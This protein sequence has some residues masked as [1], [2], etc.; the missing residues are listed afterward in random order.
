[1]IEHQAFCSSAKAHAP[2][3][4]IDGTCRVLQFA[5]YTFDA[6]LVEILTT[7]MVGACICIPSE[8]ER[9]NDIAGVINRLGVNH[10]VLTPS[11]VGFLSPSSVPGLRTLVLAGEAMSSSH[12]ATWSHIELVNGYG[13]AESSVAAVVNSRVT[14]SSEAKDIG[15]PCGVRCWVVDPRNHNRL[16][17][18][19]CVGE[20]LLEG[21]S[22]ARGYL[23]DPSKTEESFIFNPAWV[24]RITPS[25]TGE[26]ESSRRRFY[27]TG[28]LVRWNPGSGSLSYI[29]RK[30]TQIKFHGQRI[31][32]G[33]IE[34][35]LAIDDSVQHAMVLLPKLGHLAQHLV[36]VIS[37]S[38]LT[39]VSHATNDKMSG[40]AALK[41]IDDASATEPILDQV[42]A[43]LRMRLPAHMVPSTWVCVEAIPMLASRKMDRAAVTKWIENIITAEQCQQII[44]GLHAANAKPSLDGMAEH[45]TE[46]EAKLRAIWSRVL[47]LPERQISLDDRSFISLGGDSI[48]AMACTSQSKKARLGLSVQDVLRATSLRQLSACVKPME[49]VTGAQDDE[50]DAEFGLPFELS[51]IQQLHFEAR[52]EA[53]GDEHF[54]QSFR[55]RLAHHVDPVTVR[56]ALDIVVRRHA[57]LRARFQKNDKDGQWR[58]FI[59]ADANASYRFR[60]HERCSACQVDASIS[61]AQGCLNVH[62]GPI[63]AVELFS[64]ENATYQVLF[65]TGHHLVLDLVS[66]RVIL[67]EMEEILE[68]PSMVNDMTAIYRSMSFKKWISVQAA[69]CADKHLDQV[70]PSVADRVPD[71]QFAYWGMDGRANLYGDVACEGFELDAAT[72]ASLLTECHAPF[73]T[74]TCDLLLAAVIW[75]FQ[76]TFQDRRCPAIF[77]EGHG[78]EPPQGATEID[79]SR[80]VGW[81]TTLLPVALCSPSSFVDALVQTK[82]LRRSVPGNGRPYFASRF[83]NPESRER[84]AARHSDMEVSFNF[85]GRYQQLERADGLFQPAEGAHM[86]GEAH[87]GS[88]TADFGTTAH[89]FALFEVSAVIVQGC[90]RFGFA[91]NRSMSHQARIRDWVTACRTVLAEAAVALP[92]ETRRITA[93]DLVLM[94]ELTAADLTAFEQTKLPTLAKG[95]GWDAVEDV[96]PASP[97]QQG[98][99][100]SQTKDGSF[101]AVR[102]SFRI[103]VN[104]NDVAGAVDVDRVSRAWKDVVRHHALLRTVFV[105]PIRRARAASYDQVVLKDIEPSIVIRE[106]QDGE[107]EMASLVESVA[108]MQYQNDT[109]QHRLS[110]FYST[111]SS[112]VF[113][114]LEMSHTIMDGASMDI[115]L[116]DLARSYDGSLARMS[117]PLFSPF[118]ASLQQRTAEADIAFW[119]DRLAGLE[120]CH[121]PVL[122]DGVLV[123]EDSRELRSLR[124]LL[125]GL[126]A[127]LAFCT[128]N[129][130]TLSSVFEAAWALTLAYYT[131]AEDLC[132]GY[133][134]SGRDAELIEGSEDAVGPFINMATRRVKL[135]RGDD[136]VSPLQL[137][138]AVQQDNLDCMPYALTSLAEVQHGLNLPGGMPLFNTCISYRRLLSSSHSKAPEKQSIVFEDLGAIH[139]PTEYP[140][141]VNVEVG[142]DGAALDIDYWTD[143]VAT[144]QAESVAATFQQ[145]LANITQHANTPISQLDTVHQT[146]KERIWA[147]NANMPATTVDCMHHMVEKQVALRPQAQA[148]RGWDANFSYEE[149]NDLADRVAVHL[150]EIGVSPETYVPVCF[151]KSAWTVIAMLGVLKAGG[152]VVPL[153]ATHPAHAL[154]GKVADAGAQIVV[155]SEA[156]ASLCE[157]MVPRVVAVGPK[158][159]SRLSGTTTE[160]INPPEKQLRASPEDPAF[161]MFTSG[162]TGKPKGVVLCHQA[163]VS[164][165]L[166]HGSALGLSPDTRF[167]QF[168][169]H[170]FDNSIEEMFTTLIHGGCVCVPSEAD[171][172]GDLAGAIKALD[173]NFMDLTPTVAALLRPDQVPTIRAIAVGG[174]ALTKEVLD[175]W[176][177]AVPLHNQYGPS[178]CSINAMHQLHTD[179]Q[180]D[181][182]T[183][184]TSVGSVSW[185]TDVRDHNQLVPIGCVGELLI[186]GPILARGYLGRPAETAKAFIESPKW[187]ESDPR[188]CERGGRRMYKTGDI[189][190]YNSDGSL[191]Y[192]GRK[193]TQ[194]KLHGQ[195]IELGEI[196]HHVKVSL[197]PAAQSSVEL[198]T[199]GRSKALAAFICLPSSAPSSVSD[200]QAL[201]ILPMDSDF[202]TLVQTVAGALADQVAAYM[203]PSVFLPV[204]RMPLTSSGKLDRRR[205]RM[206]AQELSE[207]DDTVVAYRLGAR[208]L[209]GREPETPTEKDLQRLWAS[210]LGVLPDSISAD[211]SFFRHGGDSIGAMRLVASARQAGI[212]L[213]VASIFQSPKLCD[214]AKTVTNIDD[215]ANKV[216]DGFDANTPVESMCTPTKP[217]SLLGFQGGA[218]VRELQEQVALICR[219]DAKSVEDVYPCTPLQAGIIAASQK[220]PGAYVAVNS[221]ELPPG[222]NISRFKEAWQDIVES[223]A[224]LRT[225]VVFLPSLGFVQVVVRSN[226]TWTTAASIDALPRTHRQLPSHDGGIL[227]R[228]T[229]VGEHTGRP[230]FTWTV[231]HALYDGW[232]LPT[233]LDRVEAR[234]M[235]PEAPL[236]PRPKFS[237]FVEYFA[238]T[239][240][241]ASDAFWAA[242]L[243][244]SDGTVPQ[245][246]PKLPHP[247]YSV[248]AAGRVDRSV[249]FKRPKGSDLT[250]ASFLRAAWALVVSTYSSSNDVIFGEIL[251]GRDIPVAGVEDLVGPTLALVPR[252]VRIDRSTNVGQWMTDMQL[253]LNRAIPHQS[254]GL[255]RVRTVNPETAAACDFQNL[256]AIEPADDEVAPASLWS[257]LTGGG[258]SQSADFFSYPLNIA[259]TMGN[260]GG[261]V[262]IEIRAYHDSLVVPQWLVTRMLGQFD[263]VLQRLSDNEGQ[264]VKMGDVDLLSSDDKATI[265]Q[266]NS[267]PGPRIERLVHS[268]I[269]EQAA[270]QGS[271]TPAV[272]GWDA[273]FSSTELDTLS[274][275]LAS[276]LSSKGVG[277]KG[278]QFVP[279][280]FEKSAFAVVAILAVL[281]AGAAFVPLDPSHPIGRLREIVD[282]CSASL[283]LCSPKYEALC[284]DLVEKV[285]PVDMTTLDKLKEVPRE[286]T[287]DSNSECSRSIAPLPSQTGN[288]RSA[289]AEGKATC[290]PSDPAY[291]IFTSGTTGKPKG[292]IG[293]MISRVPAL[294]FC[295]L[296]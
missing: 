1:M 143:A 89:R 190:R 163:L 113:C 76:N 257:N 147:W 97:I 99:L 237:R 53:Q 21:P 39:R 155:A 95:Q 218:D 279:F 94:C 49:A 224:I 240:I 112:S 161:V 153:D 78:R 136:Q 248:Q 86:A 287:F 57:M 84:W 253:R 170:T 72:T 62:Q 154:Q 28:D 272:I 285:V 252:R 289:N 186:E 200:N 114:V 291:V 228:Y 126:K 115:L 132:F 195:R 74:E 130:V 121:F 284:L 206:M 8:H 90:L 24:K 266:W 258:N 77:N 10:A 268:L 40:E 37:L 259:C 145:A 292:T 226:I 179:T 177:C 79:I 275:L 280:C 42:R 125:P 255:Q 256:L 169:A 260:N 242:E 286:T 274:T 215:E 141:S 217:F 9:L 110:V 100:L 67:E 151:D 16:M 124:V 32:L 203:V 50:T 230:V 201:R 45:L 159:L 193:D 176:A 52:S 198:V 116:R 134:V 17:P 36:A 283:I 264:G 35:N 131:D 31:E 13:P 178:E 293:T 30:D 68:N 290:R 212:T 194:V 271:S 91:W 98:L 160:S 22:L 5:A 261:N 66:W 139:D 267:A 182:A 183:I 247:G 47:N 168:A 254:V 140:I 71:A 82:D 239:D 101:Y 93:S 119:T 135:D 33:E 246:F 175:M 133:L 107:D 270:R 129:A 207:D 27:K 65:M 165:A 232:S 277:P 56:D 173:A 167:L 41:L 88:A 108:P 196:E 96:Y 202:R 111:K 204:S 166:A 208:T 46:V 15:L 234:Y 48:S 235:Q 243:S 87:P 19:G 122:N 44:F 262:E 263:T 18:V 223:E 59:T 269:S 188:H 92:A 294:L 238:G 144:L 63:M 75:S 225:R 120:P 222:T 281:K 127:V 278:I 60:S 70:F 245:H 29:G 109:P 80:T 149:M 209:G 181:A 73:R 216:G 249:R 189:V 162:S 146:T 69:D 26:G 2:A 295:Q 105:A 20:L 85:L 251:S 233:L 227:S 214:M 220:T 7:L 156:R 211:D 191:V 197:P 58:Q 148:V 51:P 236:D 210:V 276:E 172:L 241:S 25:S 150:V 14:S 43:R 282:D 157:P 102:R 250:A 3:L 187:A 171:R 138:K 205:L 104:D 34:H 273:D 180:G 23:N 229:I 231:H 128:D 184:G 219:V 117:K 192:L 11:F 142:D 296:F 106:C 158:L 185:V 38:D 81:F 244:G 6:S 213:A 61:D 118:V 54:N 265:R 12:V 64:M 174:E 152:A 83:H 103:K 221:Y 4:R 199:L 55:L 123:S 164:S 288:I 137:L